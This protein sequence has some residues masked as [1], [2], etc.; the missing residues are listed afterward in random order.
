M[1]PATSAHPAPGQSSEPVVSFEFFPPKTPGMEATLM[2]TVERLA[3]LQP[4]FVSVTYGAGGSTREK[5]LETIDRIKDETSVPAAG[6]LTCVGAP[7]DK[8]DTIARHYWDKGV[9]HIVA[10]RGDLPDDSAYVPRDDGY[11]YA[12]DLVTGLKQIADF[13]ISV[14]AY[15][16]VHPAAVSAEADLD[17]L[18]RKVDAGADRAISQFFFDNATFLRF[19]DRVA[20]AGI[21]VPLVPG[22]LPITNFARASTFAEQCGA[23]I[24]ASMNTLFEGL[25]DDP[26]TRKLVAATVAVDQ[27]QELRRHGVNEFHFYTLNRA[28]LTL[29]ICRML[30]I[31]AKTTSVAA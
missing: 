23:S 7:R 17:N 3:P 10:L 28:E 5:T 25:D 8:I 29:A 16:E 13:E 11:A 22:I 12:A 19:R 30:G 2:A 21:E 31:R 27:C 6:H 26:E 4:L 15:P 18:R 9:R 24:P 14:A 20:S 1:A